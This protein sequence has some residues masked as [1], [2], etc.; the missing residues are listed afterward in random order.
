MVPDNS[1][2]QTLGDLLS[3]LKSWTPSERRM[4]EFMLVLQ[5]DLLVAAHSQDARAQSR[6]ADVVEQIEKALSQA[7]TG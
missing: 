3:R 1:D 4:V 2:Y 5:R 7:D 6:L